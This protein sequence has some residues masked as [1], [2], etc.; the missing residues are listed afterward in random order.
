VQTEIE[1]FAAADR[2]FW[3][4]SSQ[5]RA[6]E[7]FYEPGVERYADYHGGMLNF[8]LWRD[9][10]DDYRRAS[11]NLVRTVAGSIAVAATSRL[12]DVACGMG[13]QDVFLARELGC[14][15]IDG[16][17]VT[18]KHVATA[19]RRA[20]D[21]RVQ[22]RVRFHHGTAVDLPFDGESFTHIIC[23]EGAE[24]FE[25]RQRFLH[26]AFRVLAAGGRIALTDFS[27]KRTPRTA[28][29]RVLAELGRR[30]WHVPRA[31]LDT[32]DGLRRKIQSA[33]F[34]NVRI[35][36]AGADV[37]P[38]YY[39]EGRKPENLRALYQIRGFWITRA[40]LWIDAL[41]YHL[42]RRGL[43]EYVFVSAE[44]P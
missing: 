29:E 26:Q 22:E 3:P 27:M 21:A 11:E 2:R 16:I 5:E 41:V 25:T 36:E 28:F 37:I 32:A 10:V 34:R 42:H 33:G 30:G 12:L 39:A 23:I 19:R 8:G 13:A 7:R 1:S 43:L 35:E 14:G 20:R 18:W 17:D 44:K 31:N 24:H 4:R 38:G 6:V 9:G 15:S 40:S